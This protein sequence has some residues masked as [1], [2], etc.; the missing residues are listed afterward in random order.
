MPEDSA[1]EEFAAVL[2]GHNKGLAHDKASR[3]LRDAVEAVKLTGKKAT[4]TV[5]LT[6]SP[7]KNNRRAVQVGD[8]VTAAIP[9]PKLESVWYA[10]DEGGLHRNDPEQYR[11]DYE[12]TNGTAAR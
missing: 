5:A 1:F 2:V 10:D 12:P 8:K 3:L 7:L 9:E 4:V 11:I 6:I